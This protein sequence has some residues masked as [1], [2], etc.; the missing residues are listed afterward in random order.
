MNWNTVASDSSAAKSST[1]VPTA[2]K[3][4]FQSVTAVSLATRSPTPASHRISG[5]ARQTSV[6]IATPKGMADGRDLRLPSS[7]KLDCGLQKPSLDSDVG[8]AR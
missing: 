8:T 3:A 5:A 6:S 2:L 1:A 4:S 7:V